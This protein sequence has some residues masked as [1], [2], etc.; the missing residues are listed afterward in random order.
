[1]AEGRVIRVVRKC[2]ELKRQGKT[3]DEIA[4]ILPSFGADY[5]TKLEQPYSKSTLSSMYTNNKFK[6]LSNYEQDERHEDEPPDELKE[7]MEGLVQ[8]LLDKRLPKL[9]E[10][11]AYQ[12]KAMIREEISRHF[13]GATEFRTEPKPVQDDLPPEPKEIKK[14]PGTKGKGRSR[15]NRDYERHTVTVDSSLWRL[16]EQDMKNRRISSAGRMM[17][18][19]LWN[20]YGKPDLSYMTESQKPE[21]DGTEK[22][23]SDE[24]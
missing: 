23:R 6:I 14:E 9:E 19:I 5:L 15:Q 12:L 17:D 20:Y 18:V 16:F 3:W 8:D 24:E 11:L 4:N 21:E 10:S 13:V 22:P 7:R 2:H 1:M